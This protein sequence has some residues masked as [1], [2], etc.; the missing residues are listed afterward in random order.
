MVSIALLSASR[1]LMTGLVLN[2]LGLSLIQTA[3]WRSSESDISSDTLFSL[4]ACKN[5]VIQN[6]SLFASLWE[7]RFH[8]LLQP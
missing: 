7:G 1:T 8:D 2:L 5:D 6:K 4:C 3:R